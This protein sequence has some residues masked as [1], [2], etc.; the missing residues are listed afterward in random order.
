MLFSSSRTVI[1]RDEENS[2]SQQ[3]LIWGN[4]TFE[5]LTQIV[6]TVYEEMTK[7]R[8]NIFKVPSGVAGKR[9]IGEVTRMITE[10]NNQTPLGNVALKCGIYNG[11]PDASK[12]QQE[13]KGKISYKMS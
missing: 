2:I 13:V 10:W 4:H 1:V 6:S 3:P 5:D 11:A 12:A 9:F 7:W 8:K